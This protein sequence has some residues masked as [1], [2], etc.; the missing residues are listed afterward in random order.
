MAARHV[1]ADGKLVLAARCGFAARGILYALIGILAMTGRTEDPHGALGFIFRK[2]GSPVLIP[3][4]LGFLAY[5]VWR[6]V[7]AAFDG[8]DHGNDPK[9]ILVRIGG[10]ACGLVYLS[11]ALA[12]AKLLFLHTGGGG[13]GGAAEQGASTALHLPGGSLLLYAAAA[14]F[15][16]GGI[17]QFVKAWKLKFLKRVTDWAAH[18]VLVKWLGRLG[19]AA[20]GA[21]FV[22]VAWLFFNAARDL[23]ASEAGGSADAMDAMPHFLLIAIGLGLILF[24]LFSLIE[25]WFRA[26]GDPNVGDHVRKHVRKVM[27]G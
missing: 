8:D 14:A 4:G 23:K 21:V 12:T 26:I 3:M 2:A 22:T 10:A 17:W 6:V 27:P 18:S 5:G 7:D 16:G 9:G 19:F 13:G 11:F 24:G 20:R 15:L 1:A 25:A